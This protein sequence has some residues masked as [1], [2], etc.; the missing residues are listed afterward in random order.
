MRR[1]ASFLTIS[2]IVAICGCAQTRQATVTL[3]QKHVPPCTKM[4]VEQAVAALR[5]DWRY[6]FTGPINWVNTQFPKAGELYTVDQVVTLSYYD[7]L[8]DPP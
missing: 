6:E 8:N 4:T 3:P 1:L 5:G 2:T 7:T